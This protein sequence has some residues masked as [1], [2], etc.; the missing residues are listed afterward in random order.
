MQPVRPR[1][2]VRRAGRRA[3]LA[4]APASPTSC[5]CSPRAAATRTSSTGRWATCAV[6]AGAAHRQGPARRPGAPGLVRADPRAPRAGRP[7]PAGDPAPRR[8]QPTAGRPG[9]AASRPA[10][11]STATS[12]RTPRSSASSRCPAASRRASRSCCSSCPGRRCCCSTSRPTTSTCESAEALEDGLGGLRRHRPRGHP[13][14]LVRPRLRPVPGV[15]RRRRGLRVRRPGLGRGPRAACPLRLVGVRGED[16]RALLGL[17]V[18]HPGH[19]DLVA[20]AVGP[21]GRH[22]RVGA[23]DQTV[24]DPGDHVVGRQPGLGCG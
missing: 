13:R 18:A 19:G 10:G 12:S 4:T 2:L 1:G 14:P 17:A 6:G 15:R 5:G 20:G 3:R 24:V 8:R 23:G 21:D 22:Q 9:W 16:D 11:C 7:H